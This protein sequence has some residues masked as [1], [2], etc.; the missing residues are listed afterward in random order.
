MIFNNEQKPVFLSDMEHHSNKAFET[1]QKSSLIVQNEQNKKSNA[2][3]NIRTRMI[4]LIY[5]FIILY[6]KNAIWHILIFHCVLGFIIYYCHNSYVSSAACFYILFHLFFDF[7]FMQHEIPNFRN[8]IIFYK[9]FPVLI[10]IISLCLIVL[11][12]RIKC[13]AYCCWYKIYI[14]LIR[15]P[16]FLL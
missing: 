15:M 4:F 5:F 9:Y 2:D 16:T 6:K 11:E 14:S 3:R 7:F 8:W 12:S 13:L 1:I 10:E